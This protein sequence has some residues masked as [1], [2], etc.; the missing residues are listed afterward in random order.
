MKLA[1]A[2]LC[3]AMIFMT[4]CSTWSNTGKG[5]AIGGGGGA[6][7]GAGI[8]ALAGGGKG[9][10]IGSAIGA[11]V[12][13]G[14]GALIG[15]RMDKQKAELEAELKDAKV[16]SVQ[17]QNG[18]SAIKVTFNDGL[19][20]NTGKSTLSEASRISLNNF[21]QSLKTHPGTEVTILGNTDNTG[22]R[23]VNERLS[24]ERAKAVENYLL[25]QGIPVARF[26]DV[27]GL[28]YD[29]PVADNSTPEGRAANRRVDIYITAGAD[30][31]AQAESGT[32][33]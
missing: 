14:T 11:I 18:L 26:L 8:G 12:G 6:A 10:A 13:T 23:Q 5:A 24:L 21:A 16:E 7:L 17:D 4:G 28:A 19:L 32:L 30:M 9:A 3:A 25:G 31:V 20:F 2:A 29:A 27:R 22:S 1:V 33:K 15:R